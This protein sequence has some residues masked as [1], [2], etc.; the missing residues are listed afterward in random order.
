[1]VSSKTA[2]KLQLLLVG[3]GLRDQLAQLRAK[4]GDLRSAPGRAAHIASRSGCG[5]VCR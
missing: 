2:W 4:L 5:R 1:M 3:G